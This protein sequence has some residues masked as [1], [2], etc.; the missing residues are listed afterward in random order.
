MFKLRAVHLSGLYG[1]LIL[2]ELVEGEGECAFSRPRVVPILQE[3][4]PAAGDEGD[5]F[6]CVR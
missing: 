3:G 4:V 5:L 2:I 1:M 6:G